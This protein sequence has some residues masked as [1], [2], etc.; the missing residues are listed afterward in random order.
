[1][2]ALKVKVN[3]CFV[4]LMVTDGSFSFLNVFSAEYSNVL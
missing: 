2:V 3:T 1:M 4:M